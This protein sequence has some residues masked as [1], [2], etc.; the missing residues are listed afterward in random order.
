VSYQT[1][2]EAKN[3]ASERKIIANR[4]NALAST[5][6]KTTQGK[7]RAALNA[8]RHGLAIRNNSFFE[9]AINTLAQK[10]AGENTAPELT[11]IA[12]RIAG[13][14]VELR[15]IRRVR[16]D[17]FARNMNGLDSKNYNAAFNKTAVNL[18]DL[19]QQLVA[20]DRYEQRALSRRKIAI[21][22]FDLVRR[23]ASRMPVPPPAR[24]WQNEA[25]I[26]N[27]IKGGKICFIDEN[28]GGPGVRLRKGRTR[29]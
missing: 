1:N 11:E 18:T 12:M 24:F 4:T 29:K 25:K 20:V 5:G 3:M 15:R 22:A 28:G 8:H 21:R 17:I 7:A 2:R 26:F 23:Q 10:I 27:D 16:M 9:D 13:A 14:Q 6:P 19:V